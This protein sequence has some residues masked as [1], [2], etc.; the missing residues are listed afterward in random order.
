LYIVYE[1]PPFV[2]DSIHVESIA[3]IERMRDHLT[4]ARCA[5]QSVLDSFAREIDATC[6]WLDDRL[7][8]WQGVVQRYRDEVKAA[9][10]RVTT[11]QDAVRDATKQLENAERRRLSAKRALDTCRSRPPRRD[12]QG[13]VHPNDC[14]GPAADDSAAQAAVVDASKRLQSAKGALSKAEANLEAARVRLAK[15]EAELRNVEQV[16]A[17]VADAIKAYR[18][19]SSRLAMQLQIGIPQ[20]QSLLDQKIAELR[21]YAEKIE[22]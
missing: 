20:A 16:M 4:S 12:P 18:P 6:K 8:H 22:A 5:A 11:C 9:L 10:A 15:A 21:G 14:S 3:A 13:Q 2:S 7:R 19:H 1:E 17:L